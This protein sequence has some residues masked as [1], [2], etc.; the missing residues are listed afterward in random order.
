[1]EFGIMNVIK[2]LEEKKTERKQKQGGE[3]VS[4][5]L[6]GQA[7][8][9]ICNRNDLKQLCSVWRVHNGKEIN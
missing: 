1:M 3:Q 8:G 7:G 4:E 2:K 9:F 6:S 5:T